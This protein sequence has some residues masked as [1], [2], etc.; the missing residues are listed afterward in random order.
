M[1]GQKTLDDGS[2]DRVDRR[3][4]VYELFVLALTVLSL[5]V[6]V[7]LLLILLPIG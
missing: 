6:V 2:A 4:S 3:S 5:V 1:G 7:T